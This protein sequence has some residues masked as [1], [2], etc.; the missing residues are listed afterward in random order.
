M[1]RCRG[2]E[3]ASLSRLNRPPAVE[4]AAPHEPVAGGGVLQHLVGD[5]H[6]VGRR[7]G[8]RGG[9]RQDL[10]PRCLAH[11]SEPPAPEAVNGHVTGARATRWS[12]QPRSSVK[13][14]IQAT[15]RCQRSGATSLTRIEAEPS[16]RR[17]KSAPA[18]R[19]TGT[20]ACGRARARTSAATASSYVGLSLCHSSV[21]KN[22]QHIPNIA[23]EIP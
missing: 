12:C 3:F 19:V 1:P 14:R 22:V 13:V 11:P 6:E 8:V 16:C 7:L 9:R 2:C 17:M 4:G 5:G 18:L 21:K 15:D 20:R 23:W 10:P